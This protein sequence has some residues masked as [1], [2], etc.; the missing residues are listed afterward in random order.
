MC[1]EQC[2]G[3]GQREGGRSAGAKCRWGGSGHLDCLGQHRLQETRWKPPPKLLLSV[4]NL[5]LSLLHKAD[6]R[7]KNEKP[8]IMKSVWGLV[9]DA[10]FLGP[11]RQHLESESVFQFCWFKKD[12]Y[13]WVGFLASSDMMSVVP[14]G[15]NCNLYN[16]NYIVDFITETTV[17]CRE[18]QGECITGRTV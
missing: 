6:I 12:N 11:Y 1:R 14:M 18:Q 16:G 8:D 7:L 13:F 15:G 17:I 9:I 10:L 5:N 4:I 2:L 3:L